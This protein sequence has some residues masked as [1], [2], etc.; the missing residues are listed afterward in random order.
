MAKE[1]KVIK[2]VTAY[3]AGQ[4]VAS[5]L[6]QYKCSKSWLYKWLTRYKENP[7]GQWYLQKSRKPKSSRSL[8]SEQDRE[9]VIAARLSLENKPYSQKGAISIQ[10]ELRQQQA[11]VLPV[12]KINKILKGANLN[13]KE[14]KERKR[15]NEYPSI[16]IVLDQMDFV[17]PRYVKGDG[18]YYS[19]NIIDTTTHFVHINPIRGRD[20]DNVLQSV[21]RFWQQRGLPDYL[22]MDNELSFRGSN[23]HPHSFSKLI[24]LALSLRVTVVFIPIKEPWRN[25]TIEKF[26][27]SFQ[28]RFVRGKTYTSFEHLLVCAR[29]FEDFHNQFHRYNLHKNKT[30]NELIPQ[31]LTRD[32][33]P[34]EFTPSDKPLPLR[35][36]KIILVRFIR[37]D[38]ILDV[39]GERFLMPKRLEYSYILA[40]IDIETQCL[41]A[42]RDNKIEWQTHYQ[43]D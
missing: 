27:D 36:G 38:L 16:G 1:E 28:K 12:W 3:R 15:T 33:L 5:I 24:R 31:E 41:M 26:N 39:F 25:G 43:I 32:K 22:Q 13:R 14:P 34:V 19:L 20:T 6:K 2:A 4:S 11:T 42:M 17:G 7:D 9:A 8:V 18:R 40:L 29:E 10:Y 21:I 30:P 37:S 23:R 35:Q